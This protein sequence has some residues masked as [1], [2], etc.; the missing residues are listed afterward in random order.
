MNEVVE[1]NIRSLQHV[2]IPVVDIKVAEAFYKRLG[3]M[4][5]MQAAFT[6]KGEEGICVMMKRGEIIIELYQMPLIELQEVA[7]RWDGHIDHIAFDV[8]DIDQ[9]F[10]AI[11]AAG[12]TVLEEAPVFLQ[13][14]KKGCRFFNITGPDGERLEFNQIIK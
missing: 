4:N 7:G 9:A 11:K 10:S 5:V 2:G 3:F 12:F 8:P 13:F 1:L 14:W 6:H